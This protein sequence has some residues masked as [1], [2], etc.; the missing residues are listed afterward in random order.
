MVKLK[1]SAF[2]FQKYGM[3]DGLVELIGADSSDNGANDKTDPLSASANN[4][5]GGKLTYK[6]L[7]TMTNQKLVVDGVAHKLTPG[8]QAS[9]EIK[10]GSRSVMEYLFSSVTRA[11]HEAGR[12]R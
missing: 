10:L 3:I 5:S 2:A 11:F 4:K 7:I 12:E 8:M 6:A 1:I 9:A